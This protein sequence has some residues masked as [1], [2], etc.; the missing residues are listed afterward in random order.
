MRCCCWL[1]VDDGSVVLL[2]PL[3]AAPSVTSSPSNMD[4]T[5]LST[6]TSTNQQKDASCG[7]GIG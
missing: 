2:F 4:V 3:A 1:P 7:L 5:F 6:L